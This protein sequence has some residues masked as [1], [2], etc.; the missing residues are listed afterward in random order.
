MFKEW[1]KAHWDFPTQSCHDAQCSVD[2]QKD[3]TGE[4]VLKFLVRNTLRSS[5]VGTPWQ[6]PWIMTVWAAFIYIDSTQNETRKNMQQIFLYSFFSTT[7]KYFPTRGQ[8]Q[9]FKKLCK[10]MEGCPFACCRLLLMCECNICGQ[11]LS[12]IAVQAN[13]GTK[14]WEQFW[15]I[16]P[17][18]GNIL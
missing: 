11:L 12:P 8:F 18:L 1:T 3:M 17:R 10:V 15:H 6:V 5:N 9:G 7:H 14:T 13:T 4:K 2:A 16:R